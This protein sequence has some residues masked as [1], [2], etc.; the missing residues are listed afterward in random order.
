MNWIET[1]IREGEA[2]SDG[3]NTT[4]KGYEKRLYLG[5]DVRLRHAGDGYRR[6]DSFGRCYVIKGQRL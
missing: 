1:G 4:V 5:N 3:R 2:R 6:R